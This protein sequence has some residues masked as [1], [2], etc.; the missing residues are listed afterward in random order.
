[1]CNY[2][3]TNYETIQYFTCGDSLL[4]DEQK[5]TCD[6]SH[7]V[8]CNQIEDKT[9][10]TDSTTTDYPK[11]TDNDVKCKQGD[12]LYADLNS[13]CENYYQC[14]FSGTRFE[15]IINYSCPGGLRFDPI[16]KI[17]NWANQVEC[18]F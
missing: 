5:K 7:L 1:M 17:C 6:W 4:F 3:G 14:L 9:L 10:V 15:R 16:S 11:T 12:G 8:S 2:S 18:N 13:D